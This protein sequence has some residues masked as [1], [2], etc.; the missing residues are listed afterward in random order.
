MVVPNLL[1]VM[2]VT[3]VR[4]QL[5]CGGFGVCFGELEIFFWPAF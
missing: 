5:R 2:T 4:V 3:S 1:D